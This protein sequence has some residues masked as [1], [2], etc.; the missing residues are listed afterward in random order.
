[1]F[2]RIDGRSRLE[3]GNE[4]KSRMICEVCQ[5]TIDGSKRLGLVLQG[6]SWELTVCESCFV[7]M[8]MKENKD[9]RDDEKSVEKSAG[10]LE[11]WTKT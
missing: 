10:V 2:D 5:G 4:Y 3:V 6:T 1:M 7:Q 9:V 8:G 11:D